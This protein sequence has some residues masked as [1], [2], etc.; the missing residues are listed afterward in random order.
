M[1]KKKKKNHLTIKVKWIK[2]EFPYYNGTVKSIRM[3]SF[4]IKEYKINY[5]DG[6]KKW[7]NLKNEEWE[8]IK[9]SIFPNLSIVLPEEQQDLGL[10]I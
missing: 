8:F 9:D 2:S 7:H 6:D 4:D 1:Q 10:S 5:D 3:K